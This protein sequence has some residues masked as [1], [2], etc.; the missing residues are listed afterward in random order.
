[1][2]V[3]LRIPMSRAQIFTQESAEPLKINLSVSD[4]DRDRAGDRAKTCKW[5]EQGERRGGDGGGENMEGKKLGWEE[6]VNK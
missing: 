6:A 1:M 2:L 3:L 5:A 4:K